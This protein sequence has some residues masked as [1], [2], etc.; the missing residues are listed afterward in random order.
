MPFLVTHLQVIV[1][2][3]LVLTIKHGYLEVLHPKTA[4]QI[5]MTIMKY[6]PKNTGNSINCVCFYL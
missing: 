3:S 6:D 5:T 4:L 1:I 2:V